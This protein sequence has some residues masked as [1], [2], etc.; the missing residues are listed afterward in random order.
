MRFLRELT[1]VVSVKERKFKQGRNYESGPRA[2]PSHRSPG[3][4]L[5]TEP[6]L[7]AAC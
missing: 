6:A 1:A 4:P 5:S 7:T 3:Y 2:E